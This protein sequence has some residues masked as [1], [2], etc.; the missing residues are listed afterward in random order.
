MSEN[1]QEILTEDLDDF[2]NTDTLSF[3]DIL[4]G[5]QAWTEV[6]YNLSPKD[7]FSFLSSWPP[8]EE[9]RYPLFNRYFEVSDQGQKFLSERKE[10]KNSIY[11][12]LALA[13][14]NVETHPSKI[15]WTELKE[16]N[17]VQDCC[18]TLFHTKEVQD[19]ML[20]LKEAMEKKK[21]SESGRPQYDPDSRKKVSKNLLDLFSST[22]NTLKRG[23]NIFTSSTIAHSVT[24]AADAQSWQDFRSS[25]EKDGENNLQDLW[26][27]STGSALQSIC[28]FQKTGE[29]V[30]YEHTMEP[31]SVVATIQL[32]DYAEYI[33]LPETQRWKSRTEKFVLGIGRHCPEEAE[34]LKIIYRKALLRVKKHPG[35]RRT[36]KKAR[37]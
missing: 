34:A 30:G 22:E 6:E 11:Q 15:S 12:L 16:A 35:C 21:T 7:V 37:F 2:I 18:T 20:A 13:M 33:K 14:Q 10:H 25:L 17:Y 23:T 32:H 29:Q 5:F 4:D 28:C 36:F 26:D 9:K 24:Q 31:S 8:K 1:G 19:H 3:G 27:Q